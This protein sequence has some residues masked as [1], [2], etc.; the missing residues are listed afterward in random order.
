ML[1]MTSICYFIS[2]LLFHVRGTVREQNIG[3]IRKNTNLTS[4]SLK[5]DLCYKIP[6]VITTTMSWCTLNIICLANYATMV[7]LSVWHHQNYRQLQGP[8]LRF[9]SIQIG[10]FV[11]HRQEHPLVFAPRG[12]RS[13]AHGPAHFQINLDIWKLVR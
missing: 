11:I 12:V 1:G 3:C 6:M 8:F 2:D 9:F 7:V 5:K 13:H 4:F 10:P